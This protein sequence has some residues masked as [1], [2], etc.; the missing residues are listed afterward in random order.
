MGAWGLTPP[1]C[2]TPEAVRYG[3]P[4]TPNFQHPIKMLRSQI[5]TAMLHR[6]RIKYLL[7]VD[8]IIAISVL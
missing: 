6:F 5:L 2:G 8:V 7:Q 3:V 4:G 1:A